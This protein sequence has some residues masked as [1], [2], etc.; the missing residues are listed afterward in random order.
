MHFAT[1]C[2]LGRSTIRIPAGTLVGHSYS[3]KEQTS[4]D[5]EVNLISKDLRRDPSFEEEIS[6]LDINPELT[7]DQ[8]EAL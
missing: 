1:L 3:V 2:N 7:E 5:R 8:Q 6:K 4:H